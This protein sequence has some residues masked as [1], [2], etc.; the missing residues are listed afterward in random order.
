MPVPVSWFLIQY[1][2]FYQLDISGTAIQQ[3][4]LHTSFFE[5][6]LLRGPGT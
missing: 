1:V 3:E 6:L 4:D 2:C 5:I